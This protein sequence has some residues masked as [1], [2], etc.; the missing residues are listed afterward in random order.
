[1]MRMN[2]M[3]LLLLPLLILGC[4]SSDEPTNQFD[5]ELYSGK[6][7][8]TLTSDDPPSAKKKQLCVVMS[9]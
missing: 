1:M 9:L 6:P 4:A 7:I 3:V 8:D 2:R 5:A